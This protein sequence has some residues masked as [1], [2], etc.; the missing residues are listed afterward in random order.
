VG[1]AGGAGEGQAVSGRVAFLSHCSFFRRARQLFLF[2]SAVTVAAVVSL[3]G[4]VFSAGVCL[5]GRGVAAA[6][7]CSCRSELV[8]GAS[9]QLLLPACAIMRPRFC[10]N[11]AIIPQLCQSSHHH[12][13][14]FHLSCCQLVAV[15]AVDA[16][17]TL[18]KIRSLSFDPLVP[19]L[20]PRVPTGSDRPT[21]RPPSPKSRPD[22]KQ[23]ATGIQGSPLSC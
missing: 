16:S 18:V 2:L 23:S 9:I 1:G 5:S 13:V 6:M 4:H 17:I 10:A 7:P 20:Q 15:D 12:S 8:P 3:G 14:S 19:P 21:G 22:P 11:L